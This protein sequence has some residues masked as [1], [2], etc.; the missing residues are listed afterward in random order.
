MLNRRVLA[1]TCAI[2]LTVAAL[3]TAGA[4]SPGAALISA[5]DLRTWLTFLASDDLGGRGN[6]SDGLDQAAARRAVEALLIG[7]DRYRVYVRPGERP[8][9][10]LT[11][12]AA[13]GGG[14]EVELILPGVVASAATGL[15]GDGRDGFFCAFLPPAFYGPFS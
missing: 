10:S 7:I 13:P 12:R 9:G 3:G 11:I 6:Y 8:P 2:L 5:G 4:A 14:F 15:L 1:R